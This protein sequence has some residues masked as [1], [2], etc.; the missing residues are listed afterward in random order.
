MDDSCGMNAVG[1]PYE[2]KPH[3]RFDE[4]LV[5]TQFGWAPPV[6]STAFGGGFD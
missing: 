3:V 5:E 2:G 1:E 4:G 6:Y